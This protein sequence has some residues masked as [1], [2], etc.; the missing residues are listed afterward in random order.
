LISNLVMELG[1]V[2]SRGTHLLSPGW[3]ATSTSL[4]GREYDAVPNQY[5]SPLLVRDQATINR[6]TANTSNPFYPLLPGSSLSGTTVAASQ[7]LRPYPQFTGVTTVSS[8]GYSWY[9]ALQAQ[10]QR[11]LASGFTATG[12]FTWSKNME[13]LQFL[14]SADTL[15]SRAISPND[16]TLR[17]VLNG[18]Y[19]L[20]FG[21]GK[22]FGA[23]ARGFAG[24][25]IGGWQINSIYERQ[26]GDPLGFGNYVFIGDP[27]TI[28][29][30]RGQRSPDHWFNISG[31]D[32]AVADQLANNV[33]YTALRYSGVR[34]DGISYLNFSLV[35]KTKITERVSTDI[36]A[37]AF[38]ALNHTVFSDPDLSPTSSTFGQ[39]TSSAQ[40]PRTIQFGV[41]VRF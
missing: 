33:R 1:Y 28:A 34:G 37:E 17:I 25:M 6:L 30:G 14:N 23:G 32:R 3:S 29:Y 12:A 19:E 31:F 16:R 36:R 22:R 7:L 2:G 13:A 26:S 15:P 35:K 21:K 5:L 38:N 8:D 41:V 9:H 11:R 10:L 24:K 27:T 18:V 4:T 40:L 39:V 20:P